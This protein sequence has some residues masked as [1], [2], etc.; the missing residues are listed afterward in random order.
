MVFVQGHMNAAVMDGTTSITCLTCFVQPVQSIVNEVLATLSRSTS[1][2]HHTQHNVFIF[3]AKQSKKIAG[4]ED[5]SK[6]QELLS[7]RQCVIS[8]R[9]ESSA[10]LLWEPQNLNIPNLLKSMLKYL[11]CAHSNSLQEEMCWQCI[12]YWV[13]KSNVII[14]LSL[15]KTCPPSSLWHQ[16]HLG[17]SQTVKIFRCSEHQRW[18]S[19]SSLMLLG[20]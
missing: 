11:G 15:P 10:T 14:W 18:T 7:Q 20:S 6:C 13:Y 1:S 2:A 16:P 17:Y 3:R 12:P 8:E 4:D 5:N 19:A 9:L